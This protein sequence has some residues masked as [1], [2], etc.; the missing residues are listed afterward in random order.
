MKKLLA[1]LICLLACV[2]I[3]N[4]STIDVYNSITGDDN[5]G[6]NPLNGLP[7]FT[8][9]LATFSTPDIT[10]L[11]LADIQFVL[12]ASSPSDGGVAEADIYDINF[13]YIGLVGTIAD[14]SLTTDPGT[15]TLDAVSPLS[16]AP[17]T[18]YVVALGY[19]GVDDGFPNATADSSAAWEVT[20]SWLDPRVWN[21]S[22]GD[23]Y[24]G[25]LPIGG[26]GGLGATYEM[27]V[28]V[29]APEPSAFFLGGIGL[30]ALAAFR[31]RRAVV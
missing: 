30:A 8:G 16:L 26:Q 18:Q 11:S 25:L 22:A 2:A 9:L 3:A 15:Y 17:D 1:L 13:N 4:A 27:Q 5:V 12:S 7:Y 19:G 21:E 20:Y 28:D 23:A 29:N 10:G 14:S 24:D 6:P 31:R